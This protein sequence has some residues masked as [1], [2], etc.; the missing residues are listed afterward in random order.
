MAAH[1][2]SRALIVALL[3]RAGVEPN[4]RPAQPMPP[5]PLMPN[6]SAPVDAPDGRRHAGSRAMAR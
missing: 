4:P 6:S 3:L 1:A 5:M 2:V